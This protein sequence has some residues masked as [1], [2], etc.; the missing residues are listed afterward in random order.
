MVGDVKEEHV[1]GGSSALILS[2]GFVPV[3][4]KARAEERDEGF[5]GIPSVAQ[6]LV[7][8]LEV[9]GTIVLARGEAVDAPDHAVDEAHKDPR[10]VC[11]VGGQ[12]VKVQVEGH[13]IEGGFE[14]SLQVHV[15]GDPS[16][17]SGGRAQRKSTSAY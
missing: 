4:K 12:Q 16:N 6:S 15:N 11:R 10:G 2:W 13:F 1:L 5:W 17:R 14:F 8:S 3:S 7:E 9:G